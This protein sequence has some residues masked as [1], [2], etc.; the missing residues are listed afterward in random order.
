MRLFVA[1]ELSRPLQAAVASLQGNLRRSGAAVRWVDPHNAHFT[2]KFLGEVSPNELLEIDGAVR[3][4]AAQFRPIALEL[5]G[6]GRF[7]ERGRPRVIWAGIGGEVDALRG[8]HATVE[9][10]LAALG[11]PPERRPFRAHVTL[12]R[13]KGVRGLDDL[14]REIE[15]RREV[16]LGALHA[17]EAVLFASHLSPRG[18]R[19]EALSRYPFAGGRS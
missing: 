9:K 5:T 8:L 16:R 15:L 17:R 7:P 1:V 3:P 2:L 13:V 12:G 10:R 11:Y 6:L 4:A 19:Y 14:D 18:P